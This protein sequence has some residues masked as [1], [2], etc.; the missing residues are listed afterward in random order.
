MTRSQTAPHPGPLASRS[1]NGTARL[2]D[3]IA[4]AR[5]DT[6]SGPVPL[7]VNVDLSASIDPDGSIQNYYIGCRDGTLTSSRGP[8]MS[9]T[10]TKPGPYWIM[11]MVQDNSGYSDVISAYVVATPVS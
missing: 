4:S 11:L 5:L 9:C 10:F 8:N 7:T 3:H 1:V 2:R 6:Q